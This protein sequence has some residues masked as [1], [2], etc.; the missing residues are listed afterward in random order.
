MDRYSIVSYIQGSRMESDSDGDY[1]LYADA[2]A[3]EEELAIAKETILLLEGEVKVKCRDCNRHGAFEEN[4]KL[5]E[6]LA[7]A[8]D[9]A[10]DFRL[11]LNEKTAQLED[12]KRAY[13]K[14]EEE[15]HEA[16]KLAEERIAALTAEIAGMREALDRI[17]KKASSKPYASQAHHCD[18][19]VLLEGVN[20]Q[21]QQALGKVT[22]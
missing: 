4:V 8:N 15:Y 6:E 13:Q 1:V 22:P 5:R 19:R 2:R 9:R 20:N 7:E 14:I 18:Y 11:M 12:V 3:V 17:S 21:A 16:I 10:N